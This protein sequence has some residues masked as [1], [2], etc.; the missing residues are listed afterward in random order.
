VP[1]CFIRSDALLEQAHAHFT[2][3]ELVNLTMAVIAINGWNRLSISFRAEPGSY[4]PRETP[5]APAA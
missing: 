1:R 3:A 2:D 4:R 5:H